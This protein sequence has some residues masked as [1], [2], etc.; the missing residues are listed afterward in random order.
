M[1]I[2]VDL[3]CKA[4]KQTNKSWQPLAIA[5]KKYY[6]SFLLKEN[7]KMCI[8]LIECGSLLLEIFFEVYIVGYRVGI[9]YLDSL[10]INVGTY[11]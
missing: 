10:S 8:S 4:T 1:T 6:F 7:G 5:A 9:T 11:M 3:G 2:A